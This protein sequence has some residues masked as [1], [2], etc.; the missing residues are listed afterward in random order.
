MTESRKIA[1]KFCQNYQFVNCLIYI[2]IKRVSLELQLSPSLKTSLSLR[3]RS[4]GKAKKAFGSKYAPNYKHLRLLHV[5]Y[6]YLTFSF[7]PP[8]QADVVCRQLGYRSSKS[9]SIG[10]LQNKNLTFSLFGLDCKGN[11]SSLASCPT[12]PETNCKEPKSV[13]VNCYNKP[14]CKSFN[15]I[16]PSKDDQ[17]QAWGS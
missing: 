12:R 5:V 15:N 4:S 14:L 10:S 6:Y 3:P 9:F 8:K 13:S 2:Y 1:L 17:K 11:E 7:F 16:F